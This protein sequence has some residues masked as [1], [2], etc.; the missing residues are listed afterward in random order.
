MVNK[1]EKI[2]L[3]TAQIGMSYGIANTKGKP[4]KVDSFK[5]LD[6]AYENNIRYL[7]TAKIYGNSEEIIGLYIQENQ[8]KNWKI[9]TKINNVDFSITDQIKDSLNKSTD[10][11]KQK[12][13]ELQ[14]RRQM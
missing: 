9:I 6:F 10:L 7:D 12:T 11:R 14:S 5:I 3:G 8:K 4:S 13:V 1:V 2:I